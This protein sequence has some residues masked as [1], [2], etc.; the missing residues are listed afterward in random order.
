MVVLVPTKELKKWC[1][2]FSVN[3]TIVIINSYSKLSLYWSICFIFTSPSQVLY[4]TIFLI[5]FLEI[6]PIIVSWGWGLS[7]EKQKNRIVLYVIDLSSKLLPTSN[8]ICTAFYSMYISGA[9]NLFYL[10]NKCYP[11]S[12]TGI[13]KISVASN[14]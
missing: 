12:I 8:C 11:M 9:F 13:I 6:T 1:V 10:F 4:Q 2:H 5:V 14:I 7:C 3:M